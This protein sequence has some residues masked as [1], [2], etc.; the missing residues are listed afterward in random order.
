M[1]KTS[2]WRIFI[3]FFFF[4]AACSLQAQDIHFSQFQNSPLNLNPGLAGVYGGDARFVGNY[5]RQWHSVP[6]PYLTYSGSAEGKLYFHKGQYDRFL[7]GGL[8][9][10]SDDQ[11]TLHLKSLL[12]GI[13]VSVT[14]PVGRT[15]YFTVGAMPGFG[16]R[17]YDPKNLTFDSQFIGRHFDPSADPHETEAFT[18]TSLKYFDL[19]AGANLR[20]QAGSKRNRL[21]LGGSLAHIN[22]PKQTFWTS[23][24]TDPGN[25]RLYSKLALY[26]D[27][28]IQVQSNFDVVG[29]AIYQKQGGYR[30]AV[31]GLGVRFHLNQ[32]T[33]RE[34]AIQLGVDRRQ[35]YNDALVPHV[36]L[37]FRTWTVGFTYD[38]NWLINKKLNPEN[39]LV[40]NGYG[41]PELS[42]IYRLYKV[43]PLPRF[44]SCPII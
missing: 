11:G 21:D 22:R 33:Y 14:V 32:V 42:L 4:F 26:V 44:K 12:I 34:L 2:T 10:N 35:Y 13:P 15:H 28:L 5:R 25:E 36:E 37:L 24:S 8:L 31:Y 38:A 9:I 20:L 3:Y 7:S 1:N 30:E 40:T 29:H 6:V 43:K 23:K 16:Q 19:S 41:G 18:N 17:H 39:R 27:G